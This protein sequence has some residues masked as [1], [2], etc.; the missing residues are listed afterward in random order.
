MK[1]AAWMS[2]ILVMSL[3][4]FTR[5]IESS[6]TWNQAKKRLFGTAF[7]ITLLFIVVFSVLLWTMDHPIE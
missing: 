6:M 1:L 5:I 2:L 7:S 3:F 4:F